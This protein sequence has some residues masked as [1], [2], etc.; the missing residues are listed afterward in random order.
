MGKEAGENSWES[1]HGGDIG[2]TGIEAHILLGHAKGGKL[3]GSA[4]VAGEEHGHQQAD[5]TPSI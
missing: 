4:V 2:E 1:L 3:I 5:G